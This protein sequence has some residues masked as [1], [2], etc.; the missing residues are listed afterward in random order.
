M[1]LRFVVKNLGR[2]LENDAENLKF[3]LA[4]YCVGYRMLKA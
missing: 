4:E 3:V 2:N 1:A